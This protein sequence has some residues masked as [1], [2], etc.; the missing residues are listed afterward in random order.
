MFAFVTHPTEFD[1]ELTKS[2][3]SII[4]KEFIVKTVKEYALSYE[5]T[6]FDFAYRD[7]INTISGKRRTFKKRKA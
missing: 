3:S 4:N 7:K 2:L 6:H 5:K 1:K